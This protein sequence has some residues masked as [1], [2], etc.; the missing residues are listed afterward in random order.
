MA[1]ERF[2]TFLKITTN[3]AEGEVDVVE[4]CLA[5]TRM[6]KKEID[7]CCLKPAPAVAV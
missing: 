3:S 5:A 1:L 7:G 6:V 4:Y 2:S